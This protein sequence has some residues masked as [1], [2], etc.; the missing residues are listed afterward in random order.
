MTRQCVTAASRLLEALDVSVD[1]CH[2][3]YQYACGG[4]IKANTIPPG[5]SRWDTFA[6]LR[7]KNQLVIKNLLGKSVKQASERISL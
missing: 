4:W 6:A 5:L 1:P 7:R 3:F 2:D